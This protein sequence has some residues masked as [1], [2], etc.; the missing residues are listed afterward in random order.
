MTAGAI[1][2][3]RLD[4]IQRSMLIEDYKKRLSLEDLKVSYEFSNNFKKLK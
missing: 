2:H 4:E 3:L 1:Q